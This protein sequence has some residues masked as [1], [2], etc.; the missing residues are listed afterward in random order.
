MQCLYLEQPCI[1]ICLYFVK[2]SGLWQQLNGQDCWSQCG[3]Q[4]GLC[5]DFCGP[6]GYCCRAGYDDCPVLAASESPWH[7][8]CVQQSENHDLIGKPTRVCILNS[9]TLRSK[10]FNRKNNKLCPQPGVDL[11]QISQ[12]I[13]FTNH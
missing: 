11:G 5:E 3:A 10:H 6:N 8:T 4:G 9:A 7:H 2:I 13:D 1:H 12:I